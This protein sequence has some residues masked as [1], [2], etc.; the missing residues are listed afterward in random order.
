VHYLRWR[1]SV[2]FQSR[3]DEEFCILI[4]PNEGAV[5]LKSNRYNRPVSYIKGFETQIICRLSGFGGGTG[6]IGGLSSQFKAS[7][8]GFGLIPHDTL[9]GLANSMQSRHSLGL[10]SG[11]DSIVAGHPQEV[12]HIVSLGM[13]EAREVPGCRPKSASEDC[14]CRDSNR[15]DRVVVKPRPEAIPPSNYELNKRGVNG[16]ILIVEIVVALYAAFGGKRKD[17]GDDGRPNRKA[18]D[19]D[20]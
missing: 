1:Y 13:G 15:S 8:H 6:G 10:S 2:I 5:Y 3:R 20:D 19:Q 11:C 14:R 16:L 9:L 12:S 17:L 7:R 18:G 4:I